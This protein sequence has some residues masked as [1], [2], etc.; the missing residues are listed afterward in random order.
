MKFNRVVVTGIG[1][2]TPVEIM[3]QHSG[4]TLLMV[5]AVLIK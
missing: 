1:A 2:I 4:K 3:L 5:S